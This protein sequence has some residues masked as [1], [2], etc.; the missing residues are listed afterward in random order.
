MGSDGDDRLGG[1]DFDTAVANL[2][3]QKNA[4]VLKDLASHQ[5]DPE[6]FISK[7]DRITDKLPLCSVSS[8]HTLGETLKISLSQSGGETAHAECL[9][10]P[11][12]ND[13]QVNKASSSLETLCESSYVLKMNLTLEEYN[14]ACQPLFDRSITPVTRLLDDLTLQKSEIDEIVMVGGTTRMPQIREIVA[15]A[16]SNAQMNTHI[17]PD[18]TVAYGAASVID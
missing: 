7:C 16:F 1:A 5:I 11:P 6:A 9:A 4:K 3:A 14:K 18:I 2:L 13:N 15:K 17:D 10:L 8:F 12:D